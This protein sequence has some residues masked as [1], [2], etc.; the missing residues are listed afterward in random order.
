MTKALRITSLANPR[1]K[2]VVRLREQR[3][4]RKTG[5]FIAEGWREVSRAVTAGLIVREVYEC[6][7]LLEPHSRPGEINLGN[8]ALQAEVPE[9]V[10]RKMAY[11]REPEGVL[12]VVEQPKWSWE[13]LPPANAR[14]LCLVAVGIAKP[15]NL[16]A[17]VRTADAAGCAAVIAAGAVVDA[18]NPNA[19]RTSTAA[20]FTMP[21]IAAQ[22]Q[23]AIDRLTADGWRLLASTLERATPH[24][25]VNYHGPAAVV[26]GPEDVGLGQHWL[27][28]AD[29]SGGQRV[30][31]P[32]HGR[33]VDSLNASTA[34][35]VLLF[36]ARRQRAG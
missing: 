18:F 31:I 3:H 22:E 16:G 15:G 9:M 35:A 5:L 20:V 17:M 29:H 36:E 11:V 6:P 26:I 1:I 19:I 23:E 34:A 14:K 21:V 30:H 33:T 2:Q 12:A 4:R 8:A 10:F 28:A 25:Q 13:N 27:E 24:A 32:M 7:E